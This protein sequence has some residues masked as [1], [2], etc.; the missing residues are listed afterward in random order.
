MSVDSGEGLIATKSPHGPRETADR[1]ARA[2]ADRAIPV[3]ARI[4]HAAAAALAG[5]D[6]RPTEVFIFG[7]A[8]VGTPLM[9]Q[10]QTAGIDLPLRILVWQDESGQV[11]LGY[12]DPRR[13]AA[14][15]G[16]GDG[17]AP[18]LELMSQTL[19]ALVFHA[20]A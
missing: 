17:A 7:Q 13:L 5:L 14:R 6:L 4:D 20:A 9:Q 3:V 1:L 11:W 19:A 12:T 8:K 18:T 10:A 16:V 15:H 2:I